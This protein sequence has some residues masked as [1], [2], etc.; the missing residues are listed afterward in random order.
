[1]D[2]KKDTFWGAR[3]LVGPN[4]V[5]KRRQKSMSKMTLPWKGVSLIWQGPIAYLLLLTHSRNFHQPMSVP[6]MFSIPVFFFCGGSNGDSTG[7]GGTIYC[8][9]HLLS[10]KKKPKIVLHD[11]IMM[12]LSL[13]GDIWQRFVAYLLPNWW[14]VTHYLSISVGMIQATIEQTMSI[15]LKRPDMWIRIPP[16]PP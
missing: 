5:H 7:C 9:N 12:F 4:L 14:L 11:V 3:A 16:H 6:Y 8:Q 10:L 13:S 1:M 2:I 15:L